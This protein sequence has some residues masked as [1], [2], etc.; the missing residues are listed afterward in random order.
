[1]PKVPTKFLILLLFAFSLS[2][3]TTNSATARYGHKPLT[4]KIHELVISDF[5]GKYTITIPPE[6]KFRGEIASGEVDS[7]GGKAGS[8][9][10]AADCGGHLDITLSEWSG[11]SMICKRS[12]EN[13]LAEIKQHECHLDFAFTEKTKV[14]IN[15]TVF[16][17]CYFHGTDLRDGTKTKESGFIMVS[18]GLPNTTISIRGSYDTK[19]DSPIKAQSKAMFSL[20]SS[21]E[22]KKSRTILVTD[23]R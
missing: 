15:G 23:C 12:I 18:E 16:R 11:K 1:M 20:I 13:W 4:H 22:A 9:T 2:L 7:F 21:L 6:C 10:W 17:R 8:F 14:K 19:N 5:P 3:L